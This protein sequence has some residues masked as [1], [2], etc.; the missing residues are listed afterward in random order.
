[1]DDRLSNNIRNV[2]YNVKGLIHFEV[3]NQKG[4]I[5]SKN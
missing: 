2:D 5:G 1:M 4:S 3:A